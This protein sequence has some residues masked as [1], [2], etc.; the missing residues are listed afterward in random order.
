MRLR[1]WAVVAADELR[2]NLRRPL[3]WIMVI[4]IGLLVWGISVG[5]VQIV[6]GSGD[7]SVGGRKAFLTSEFAIS[8]IVAV[9]SYTLYLFVV[10]AAAGLS[11]IRDSDAG[12]L[13]LLN[14]TPLTPGEYAWGKFIGTV[15][16][17]LA[18]LV[19]QLLLMMAFLQW[20]P[21]ADML[22]TRGPFVIGN[23]LRPAL[24]FGV[25]MIL[26]TAGV[27]FWIGTRTR[28]PILVFVLP[29][30]L[31]MLCAFFLWTWSPSW[32]SE[33]WNRFLQAID[34]AGVRWL[35]ETWLKVDRG[36][37]F[38]NSQ[39]VGL[40]PIIAGNR[41][42]MLI[43]GL[44]SAWAGV[45]AYAVSSRAAH[46]VSASDVRK[47]ME[48]VAPVA[49]AAVAPSGGSAPAIM[50]ISQPPGVWT[51]AWRV[52]VAEARELRSQAGLYLFVP[53]IL[54]QAISMSLTAI[55]PFDTPLLLVPGMLAVGQ[56][57][58]LG[59]LLALLLVFY[60]VES[61][62]RERSSRL[63]A[64][65]DAIALS[66]TSIV[67]GKTMA[68]GVVWLV[69]L[70]ACLLASA[71]A[72]G[73]QGTVP[74]SL[75]PF[76]LVWV[77]LLL[78]TVLAWTMFVFA[79]FAL[80]RNR[81]TTYGIAL[82]AIGL[83][84]YLL[85]KG[86]LTWLTNWPLWGAVRWSDSS[87]FE[88]DR[89][90][91]ILNR[92][93]LLAIAALLA[94]ICIN[95]YPRIESDAVRRVHALAPRA[96]WRT[97]RGS[98]A[99]V[100]APLAVG[101]LLWREIAAG[102][103]G[104]EAKKEARDYW[105]KNLATWKDVP[106]PWLRD[107]S[108]DVVLH[109]DTRSWTVKG[110]YL[111][112]NQLQ[113]PIEEIPITVG[114]WADMKFTRDGQPATPDTTSH[115]YVFAMPTPLAP[116]DTVRIGFS[117]SGKERGSTM[118]G[119]GASTFIVPSGLVMTGFGPT[120]FPFVGYIESVGAEEEREYEPKQY[121]PD[122]YRGETAAAFGGQ[123]PM[124]V[125]MRITS[126]SDMTVNGV[127]E[128]IAETTAGATTVTE[129]QTDQ[130]VM[131]FNLVGGRYQIKRGNGTALFF[132][133]SHSYN[134]TEMLDAL[135]NARRWYGEWFG[136]FPWKELRISEFPA[137]ANYAQGFPT[138]IT[139]SEGI[140]FLTKSEP[141]T[142]L[143]FMVVAHES[144]HQWWGNMVQPG[145]GP[146][147]N[148]LSEGM[149]HFS[150]A[151][152]IEKVKGVRESMEFR[153]RIESSYGDRR[154]A[155]AERKMFRV[156]GSKLGDNTLW[157]DK[158]GWVFWM[159][160]EQMGR[161]NALRGMKDFVTTY[162]GNPDHPVLHDLAEH[163]RRF[164]P[165]T[166]GYDAFV[167]QWM[168]TVVVPEFKVRD[169]TTRQAA[170]SGD[171]STAWVTT[172]VIENAGTGRVTIDVA[173][174]RGERFP[175]PTAARHPEPWVST[176]TTITLG[177]NERRAISIR[178]V[179]KPEKVVVDPDVRVL[180]LRRQGAEARVR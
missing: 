18:V 32:L 8:Q 109:P 5:G 113:Q 121:P 112:A 172:A 158:G 69:I 13:E 87:I 99:F 129:W 101:S 17:F 133:P 96:L 78:P 141:R 42:G 164:A 94:R 83:T 169:A 88:F 66:N 76:A 148:F 10:S 55:G 53:L 100:L 15:A 11:V 67:L 108:L 38:Y 45:R 136:A 161:E 146:G 147:G 150:T 52:A 139:F 48:R 14:A 151:L 137:L 142:N 47:A 103:G 72:I 16:A 85:I 84:V 152:L 33:S 175:D 75:G 7:A 114:R 6:I 9:L 179:F 86:D 44:A 163:L 176:A 3:V 155:D 58:S 61:L 118:A 98:W 24:L 119:G 174:T 70:L 46:A 162:R 54:L 115:L 116:G 124:T 97:V 165:D 79:T 80:T 31:T 37:A 89:R 63:N 20:I 170:D 29:V 23:Y 56:L 27:A 178:S 21:N 91:L 102:P 1:R 168:D 144:A 65:Q 171:G 125:R 90:A 71:I 131:A 127:G 173:A 81:F 166:A 156:D 138:N 143:A 4:L 106:V 39:H 2:M 123:R 107:A 68:L 74:F 59:T 93:F 110:S 130:P 180:Q 62:E 92:L 122:W 41:V 105:R 36:A 159:L 140:G 135:D 167:K 128:R 95:S 120:Y 154:Q 26:F 12:V 19:L 132:H 117:Y 43:V 77:L 160:A 73:I 49:S 57:Q 51:G 28:R 134:T 82:V 145:V 126:P 22:E 104:P 30:V 34:P 50:G 177:A 111:I 64:I 35:R 149:A 153:K 60:G 157:Y 25:P 40:D